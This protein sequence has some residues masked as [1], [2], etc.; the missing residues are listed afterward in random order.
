MSNSKEE[1]DKI[2]FKIR[3]LNAFTISISFESKKINIYIYI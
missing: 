1:N 2:K 3:G